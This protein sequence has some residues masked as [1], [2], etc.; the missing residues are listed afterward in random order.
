GRG[1]L[2]GQIAS[3]LDADVSRRA[4]VQRG[5][6]REPGDQRRQAGGGLFVGGDQRAVRDER[7]AQ[8]LQQPLCTGAGRPDHGDLLGLPGRVLDG[9]QRFGQRQRVLRQRRGQAGEGAVGHRAPAIVGREGVQPQ[10]RQQRHG[11][12]RR[13]GAVVGGLFAGDQLL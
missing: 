11:G 9:Q 7:P 12:P 6:V 8:G 1:V 4:S 3:P 13:L 2:G 10:R 5:L